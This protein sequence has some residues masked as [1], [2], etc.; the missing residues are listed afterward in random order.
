MIGRLNHVAI[1]TGDL[2]KA[3]AVYRDM[4]GAKISAPVPQPATPPPPPPAAVNQPRLPQPVIDAPTAQ[5]SRPNF[6]NQSSAGNNIQ[7]AT[8]Q[9]S[10]D[11]LGP[12]E[13]RIDVQ[14]SQVNVS[15][16]AAHPDT[17]SALEQSI[18]QLRAMLEERRP[19]YAELASLTVPTDDL[20]PEEVAADLAKRLRA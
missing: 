20:A 4:L 6:N 18:P 11:H 7:S 10:P 1:A 8:L 2:D 5:P 19:V 3:S 12:V 17:R 13:V 16:T 14:S 15:F 9:V